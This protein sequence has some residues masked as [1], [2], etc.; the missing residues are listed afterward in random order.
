[1]ARARQEP[2]VAFEAPP[3]TK[4]RLRVIGEFLTGL[5]MIEMSDASFSFNTITW[6]LNCRRRWW[7]SR[8]GDER[9]GSL[10]EE[11]GHESGQDS[12]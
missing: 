5:E 4:A 11:D 1:M 9:G 7:C 3:Q 6:V 8:W 2:S 12:G 10:G